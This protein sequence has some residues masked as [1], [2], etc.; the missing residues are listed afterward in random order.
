MVLLSEITSQLDFRGGGGGWDRGLAFNSL[1]GSLLV[2]S[3]LNL[4]LSNSLLLPE[5]TIYCISSSYKTSLA[6]ST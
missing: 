3:L 4:S 2:I 5:V 1:Q 6:S